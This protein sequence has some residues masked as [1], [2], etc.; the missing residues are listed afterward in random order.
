[1]TGEQARLTAAESLDL[2]IKTLLSAGLTED[3]A[4]R[5]EQVRIPTLR[6]PLSCGGKAG[7]ERRTLGGR[8]RFA[9]GPGREV[10]ATVGTRTT[11]VYR[12]VAGTV[13][14]ELRAQTREISLDELRALVVVLLERAAIPPSSA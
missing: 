12:V 4:T 6:A 1:M 7:G 9:G 3:G 14:P 8:R 13:V 5:Q 10:R 11:F 2:V